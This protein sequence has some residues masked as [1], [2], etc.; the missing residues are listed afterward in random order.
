MRKLA[1]TF[2]E[3]EQFGFESSDRVYTLR[4]FG[5]RADEFKVKVKSFQ[6]FSFG[7]SVIISTC[8]HSKSSLIQLNVNSG[9]FARIWKRK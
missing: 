4:E 9:E 2:T 7:F 8:R 5:E 1:A 6:D 3:S